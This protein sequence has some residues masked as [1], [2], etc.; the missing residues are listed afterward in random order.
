MIYLEPRD[1]YDCVLSRVIDDSEEANSNGT[2]P[3]Y[4][5]LTMKSKFQT[6]HYTAQKR[7]RKIDIDYL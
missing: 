1:K 5:S 3:A 7:E 4:E 2:P 6:N